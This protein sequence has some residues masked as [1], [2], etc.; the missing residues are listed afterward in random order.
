M[1]QTLLFTCDVSITMKVCSEVLLI[2][3]MQERIQTHPVTM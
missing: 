2:E 3:D 1:T